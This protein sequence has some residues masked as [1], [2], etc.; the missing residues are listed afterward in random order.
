[1][2]RKKINISTV[3]AGQKP[4][5]KEVDDGIWLTSFMQYDFGC[6]DLSRERCKPSTI[7]S[8]RDCR[9]YLRAGHAKPGAGEGLEYRQIRKLNQ[10][11]TSSVRRNCYT[12]WAHSAPDFDPAAFM[13]SL[14]SKAERNNSQPS[15]LLLLGAR[16][17]HSNH[18]DHGR[19]RA[20]LSDLRAFHWEPCAMPP[21]MLAVEAEKIIWLANQPV[22]LTSNLPRCS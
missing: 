11:V 1:M 16:R 18:S 22:S 9:P 8:A 14:A 7:R 12:K 19:K 5:I 6:I 20:S 17:N 3:L 13:R 4:G 15:A 10:Q 21:E 2:R